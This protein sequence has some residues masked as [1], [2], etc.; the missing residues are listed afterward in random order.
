MGMPERNDDTVN[1]IAKSKA[2]CLSD[3]KCAGIHIRSNT[4]VGI[5]ADLCKS[6]F[7]NPNGN[8]DTGMVYMRS[9]ELGI[10]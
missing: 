4:N 5:R 3:F 10:H 8:V 9:S 6:L 7:R 1:Y 2:A